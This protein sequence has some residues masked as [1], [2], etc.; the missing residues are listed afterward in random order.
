MR[1]IMIT[2]G[3]IED[4][5]NLRN[6]LEVLLNKERDIS[7]TF[8]YSTTEHFLEKREE[9]SEPFLMFVDLGLPG[10]SGLE[11]ISYIREIWNETHIVIITGNDDNETILDCIQRGANGYLLK[12][13]RIDDLIKQI[14]IIRDG[15]AL[16]T[17][18]VAIKLFK[19]IQQPKKNIDEKISHLTNREK[20][21]VT[22]L[23]KGLTYKEIAI[24][25][26]VTA[27]T[28]ND[29][30]KNIYPKMGVHTKSELVG[31]LLR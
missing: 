27:G 23:I 1:K 28:V 8:S 30:L 21:V 17:P 11:C 14:N 31:K 6:N 18:Q 9:L 7:I 24:A 3:I 26:Q 25:L 16:I 13:F 15:G 22:E 29:H 12:P 2:I 4:D 20:D 10:I 5:R 19:Q